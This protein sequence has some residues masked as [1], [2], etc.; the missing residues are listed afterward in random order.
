VECSLSPLA[1]FAGQDQQLRVGREHFADGLLKLTAGADSLL[2]FLDP[3]LGD[4]L[5]ASFPS[6]HEDERP[7]RM[8]LALS[9]VTSGF[10]TA[11]V[12]ED[13][14]TR[15]EIVRDRELAE[16]CKL[17]LPQARR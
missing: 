4:A 10:P 16:E 12:V 3:L 9:T 7:G 17:A 14:R 13:Q 11:G 8:A 5:G 15:E 1:L 2:D 6:R